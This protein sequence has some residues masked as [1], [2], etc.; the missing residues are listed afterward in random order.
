MTAEDLAA[1]RDLPW[2]FGFHADMKGISKAKKR[3]LSRGVDLAELEAEIAKDPHIGPNQR[4]SML[5][6]VR[7]LA[8]YHANRD[9]MS[10]IK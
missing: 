8:N 6:V 10:G 2:R 4:G 3:T 1:V 9:Q 5:Q 7:W